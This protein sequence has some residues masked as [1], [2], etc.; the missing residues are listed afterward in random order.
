MVKKGEAGTLHK[1]LSTHDDLQLKNKND[2]NLDL[3]RRSFITGTAMAV[4][5]IGIS[6]S[7]LSEDVNAAEAPIG[8]LNPVQRREA[9]QKIRINATQN[10][11]A[12]NIEPA[13]RNNDEVK[14]PDFRA[15][16]SKTL[17]HDGNNYKVNTTAYKTLLK[18]LDSGLQSD[19]DKIKLASQAERKLANPQAAY[20]FEMTGEDAH[21]TRIKRAPKLSSPEQASEMAEVY[22]H[23]LTREIPFI[24][25]EDSPLIQRACDDLSLFSV[26]ISPLENGSITPKSLFRGN[27]NQIVGPYVS[28]FLY[29]PLVYGPIEIEQRYRV[30]TP[31]NFMLTKKKRH[32]IRFSSAL[33]L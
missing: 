19:F 27:E 20:A 15:V 25:F 24:E 17:P 29:Q 18:A 7:L 3:S 33:H 14:F 16:F 8:P 4:G 21:G 11:L 26:N 22:W 30:P 2:K 6:T 9:A 1:N 10:Y 32:K 31:I 12:R 5:T 23:S 28:Q 13:L